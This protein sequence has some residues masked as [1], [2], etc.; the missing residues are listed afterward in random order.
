MSEKGRAD[1]WFDPVCPWCWI[2]SRWI[3]EVQQVRDVEV[4]FHL[5]SLAVL[6][7]GKPV[8]EEFASKLAQAWKPV[9]VI[10][11][12]AELEGSGILEPLYTA[13]GTRIHQQNNQDF[14]TVI[15]Q[16]LDELG[17]TA[18]LARMA[19]STELDDSIRTSHHQ[20][21]DKVNAEVGTPIVHVNGVAYFGPV[22]SRIPR[23]EDAGALWDAVVGLSRNPHFFDIRRGRDEEPEFD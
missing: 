13:M 10:A 5:M 14:D 2:T 1:I 21:Y 20:G 12:A 19:E 22:L 17:L 23:G 8:P 7:D 9:R 6:N 15:A 16:S 4:E 18:D 11:A 3:L